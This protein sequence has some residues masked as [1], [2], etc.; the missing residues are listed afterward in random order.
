MLDGRGS[1]TGDIF[2]RPVS[3][4]SKSSPELD[5]ASYHER[6]AGRLVVDPR[7]AEKAFGVDIA[8]KL[9]LTADGQT[10]L[11]PQPTAD[12]EDPQ[13]WSERR[14]TTQLVIITLASILPDFV[15]SIGVAAIFAL[16]DEFD[17][18]T[19]HVNELSA[20]WAI[21]LL[22]WGGFAAV[23]VVRRW[24]RLPVLFYSQLIAF[25]FLIL[26]TLAPNLSVFAGMRCIASFFSTAAQITGLYTVADMWPFHLQCRKLNIWTA[27]FIISPFVSPFFLGF[28]VA[29]AN[30]RWAYGVGCFLSLAVLIITVF[31][32]EETMY[33]RT[34]HPVPPRP[35]AGL[36]YR[37][38]T[39][40]GL[41]GFKMSSYR[42]PWRECIVS[43]LR[44][45]WRPQALLIMLYG[46]V[47][48]G[49]SI[50]ITITNAIFIGTP[51]PTGFGFS[52]TAISLSYATPIVA[53]IIGEII[54]RY[55][56]DLFLTLGIRRH[57]GVH[58]AE[59]RLW[60]CYVS[61]PLCLLGFLLLGYGFEVLNVGAVIMGW[62]IGQTAIML[63]T[64][65]I[66]AYLKDCFPA[67]QG[68]VS[69][70]F[71]FFRTIAGFA[72]VYFQAEWL[73]TR[74][75]M[76]VFG[77]EAAIVGGLFVLV[78][79]LLQ[80][81]G[82]DMRRNFALQPTPLIH[83]SHSQ[84]PRRNTFRL[85]RGANGAN[86]AAPTSEFEMPH[87]NLRLTASPTASMENLGASQAVGDIEKPTADVEANVDSR[88]LAVIKTNFEG[89][90]T[91]K[92]DLQL[93][94]V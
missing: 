30:Y 52:Q 92:V 41:T 32:A 78:V 69:A 82:G 38:E 37:I 72:V 7:E 63:N 11:W 47:E 3:W 79:P 86:D 22:G 45:L 83:H 39:L 5:L 58:V 59:T 12:P 16:A 94:M 75:G 21:F 80:W 89:S 66:Y 57:G 68:E 54:G 40:L 74:G 50:G 18:T 70:L 67:H 60:M 25:I 84:T 81:R 23:I 9:K 88:S 36:R 33:D 64:T 44:V 56:N 29:H 31:F 42:P 28:L 10:I 13:N 65:A 91:S 8:R 61:L 62:G 77:C 19:N 27:G 26:G 87:L 2:G 6:N 53:T 20:N 46:G 51:P 90:S 4:S 49:L 93:G 85:S 15:G 55:G 24:G 71:N 1:S 35:T 43:P 48:F 17:T 76:Q 14:K 34:I 73:E